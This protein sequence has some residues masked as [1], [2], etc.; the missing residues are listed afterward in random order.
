[1]RRLNVIILILYGMTQCELSE[2]N[3]NKRARWNMAAANFRARGG[4]KKCRVCTD[5]KSWSKAQT[6]KKSVRMTTEWGAWRS[7]VS[8]I[9]QVYDRL[10]RSLRTRGSV[11]L[12]GWSWGD[13]L[14]FS[15]T[16]LRH[17]TQTGLHLSSSLIWSSLSTTSPRCI[18]ARSVQN[19]CRDGESNVTSVCG[20]V[21]SRTSLNR[22][23]E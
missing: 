19:T 3:V 15:C 20:T 23:L 14:G 9:I 11:L 10:A 4:D 16:P 18:P 5:F 21:Y 22:T 8:I 17:T 1:M 2:T 12:T 13:V 6:A 7:A